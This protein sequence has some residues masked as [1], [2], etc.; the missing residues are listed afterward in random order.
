MSI[1]DIKKQEEKQQFEY[2]HVVIP[3]ADMVA[4]TEQR[5]CADIYR[6]Y[7]N[8]QL[9]IK[10]DFQ[11]EIVWPRT[12]QTRFIDSLS[13]QLPIPSMCISLDYQTEKRWVVDGL[14]RI[15]SIISFLGDSKNRFSKLEDV[16]SKISGKTP[17]EIKKQHLEVYNRIENLPIPI[18]VLRCDMSKPNHR[19]Y[20]FT[21][22]HRLNAGGNKL[23]N[24][25]IRNCIYSGSLNNFLKGVVK[26][27]NFRSLFGLAQNKHYR[28]AYEELVL[29]IIA[30]SEKY[31]EYTGKLSSFLNSYMDQRRNE[32]SDWINQMNEKIED[33]IRF[34]FNVYPDGEMRKMSKAQID[35]IFGAVLR[36]GTAKNPRKIREQL[37]NL[38]EL[39]IESLQASLSDKSKVITRMNAVVGVFNAC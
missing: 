37:D 31:E 17:E 9:E 29:R 19:E 1:N 10:P 14:Q 5:S 11:R 6:M 21:I 39:Q 16:D 20:L 23:N 7:R 26:N 8:E 33:G 35:A 38:G 28:Y 34:L 15:S 13:K 4:F 24:Q 32:S 36:S 3:P 30:F 27:K 22:F 12:S 25:E 2:D 18:T